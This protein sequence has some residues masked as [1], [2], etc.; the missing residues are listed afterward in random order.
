MRRRNFIKN[1][2]RLF[3]NKKRLALILEKDA[4]NLVFLQLLSRK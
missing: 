4:N 3:N 1:K 2:N